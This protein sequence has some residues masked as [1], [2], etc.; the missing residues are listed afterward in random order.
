ML[1]LMVSLLVL[2]FSLLI[3][4]SFSFGETFKHVQNYVKIV[5][6]CRLTADQK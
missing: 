4:A 6:M 3:S 2:S 1:V 5:L